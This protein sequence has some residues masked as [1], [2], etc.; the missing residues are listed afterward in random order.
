MQRCR[1][2]EIVLLRG[3]ELSKRKRN[4]I[5]RNADIGV[6]ERVRYADTKIY[7]AT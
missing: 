5:P 1:G 3:S 4:E 6:G 2:V 7:N